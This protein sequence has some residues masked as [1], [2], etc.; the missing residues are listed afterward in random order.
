MKIGYG[1]ELGDRD[2][3]FEK[4]ASLAYKQACLESSIDITFD[5]ANHIEDMQEIAAKWIEEPK[6]TTKSCPLSKGDKIRDGKTESIFSSVTIKLC[7][8]SM[9][10][11]I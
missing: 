8:I 5:T 4:W 3:A 6:I 11:Q 9:Q 1:D 2:A 7:N 10:A